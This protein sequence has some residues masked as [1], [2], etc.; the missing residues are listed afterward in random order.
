MTLRIEPDSSFPDE[1]YEPCYGPPK[2]PAAE[3]LADALQSHLIKA[4][5]ASIDQGMKPEE[6]LAVML[7]WMSSEMARLESGD[8]ARPA[9]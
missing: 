9:R 8:R 6:A 2:A 3:R 4:F 1:E 7:S 5:E